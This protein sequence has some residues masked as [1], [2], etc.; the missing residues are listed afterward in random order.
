LSKFD[1]DLATLLTRHE[2]P[3]A[4][5]TRKLIAVLRELRPDLRAKV[6]PGW[7]SIN[8]TH[9]RAGYICAVLPQ[10]KERNVLLVFALGKLLDSPLLIDNGL[11][12]QVRW[13][14]LALGDD[15]PVDDIAI[16]LVEAIALRT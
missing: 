3:I 1:D 5:L 2:K 10:V 8:F 13:I 16:L 4:A 7:G 11:V 14:P 15:L 6:Q 9:P 12:K